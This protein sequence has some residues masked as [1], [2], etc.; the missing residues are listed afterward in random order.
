MLGCTGY[1]IDIEIECPRTLPITVAARDGVTRVDGLG[2]KVVLRQERG[3]VHAEH[4]KGALDIQNK[5]GTIAVKHCAGPLEIKARGNV[6]L[7][8]IYGALTVH[9]EDG[10]VI[11]EAPRGGVYVRNKNGDVRILALKGFGGDW[12]V[13]VEEGG[14]SV[15]LSPKANAS[16]RLIA[17][18][19]IVRTSIPLDGRVS[20]NRQEFHTRLKEGRHRVLLETSGGDIALE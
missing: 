10:R 12:D 9:G 5:H 20:K 8:E 7:K 11:I 13:K 1:R 16:L 19:G 18:D 17:Q 4:L 15:L 3:E 14:L 2:G 6:T